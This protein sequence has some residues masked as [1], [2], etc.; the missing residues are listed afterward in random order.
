MLY[1]G[2]V[3]CS[4]NIC[5]HYNDVISRAMASQITSLA[6]IYPTVCSGTEQRKHQSSASLVFARGIHCLPVNSPHKG[7]VARKKF[8]FDDVI[9][10]SLFRHMMPLD[11]GNCRLTMPVVKGRGTC[12]LQIG[13]TNTWVLRYGETNFLTTEDVYC[14]SAN[15]IE[16]YHVDCHIMSMK[17]CQC[18]NW[19]RTAEGVLGCNLIW[20]PS[21][22]IARV[23]F[24]RFANVIVL[25]DWIRIR[26]T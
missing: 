12:D 25:S 4:G 16:I 6:I 8:P 17:L 20:K 14:E 11:D 3:A 21:E 2:P 9:M 7:P 18:L 15:F 1:E 22:N 19:Y 23:S 10:F 24:R 5:C 13:T 26:M